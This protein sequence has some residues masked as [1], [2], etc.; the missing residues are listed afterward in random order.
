MLHDMELPRYR[1]DST[2][3]PDQLIPL[4][5]QRPLRFSEKYPGIPGRGAGFPRQAQWS[6]MIVSLLFW[7]AV[8]L[9]I[10]VAIAGAALRKTIP[11]L[12]AAVLVLP[13]SAYLAASPRFEVWGLFPVGFYLLAAAAVR[14]IGGLFGMTLSLSLIAAVS[15]FF[16]DFAGEIFGW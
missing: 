15:W 4:I 11:L 6:P 5:Q 8:A 10:L 7:P 3:W 9:S 14:W 13:A 2:G 1:H 16:A 12:A